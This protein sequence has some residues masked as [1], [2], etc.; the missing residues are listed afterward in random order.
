ME[1]TNIESIAL[2]LNTIVCILAVAQFV[3][4]YVLDMQPKK[5]IY[6]V[7][8]WIGILIISI[9]G[10]STFF[11]RVY[12]SVILC[13]RSNMMA[14]YTFG[15]GFITIFGIGSMLGIMLANRKKCKWIFT[16]MKIMAVVISPLFFLSINM[17]F[18]MKNWK[19]MK[20]KKL[21]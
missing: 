1:Y 21:L 14:W 18:N 17:K 13:Y 3:S 15:I 16:K 19:K 5:K 9:V 12:P 4:S 20:I 10:G 8:I 6:H 11:L 7:L 2:V